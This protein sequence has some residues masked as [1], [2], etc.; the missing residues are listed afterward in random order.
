MLAGKSVLV[1]GGANGIGLAIVQG[2]AAAG[3]RVAVADINGDAAAAAAAQAG[4]EAMSLAV[5]V[6]DVDAID[7]MV[8][9]TVERY[10]QLDVIVNNAGVTRQAGIMELT[11]ADWD[12]MHRVNA[13]GVFFCLQRAARQM[14]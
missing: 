8:A 9:A 7:K 10:G 14:I 4:T 3:A 1:T 6:G 11:E 12:R 13:K 5:D 2:M